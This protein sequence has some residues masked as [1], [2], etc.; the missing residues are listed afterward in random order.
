MNVKS[1]L[2]KIV[3]GKK[4]SSEDYIDHLRKK[5]AYVGTGTHFYSPAQI[6]ID[7]QYPWLIEIGNNVQL[8]AGVRI[9][10]HDYSWAV[11]KKIYGPVLGSAGKVKIEDNVFV[12]SNTVILGETHIGKNT[13]IGAGSVVKGKI[14]DNCVAVG[15]PCRPVESIHEYYKKRL[16][17]QF[18]EAKELAVSYYQH[19]GSIPPEELFFEFFFLF[20]G[21]DELNS[22]FTK[23]MQLVGNY[24]QSKKFLMNN[25]RMFK[26]YIEFI[27]TVLSNSK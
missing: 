8:T 23:Q 24:Q 5:G 6:S 21:S 4:A 12:G 7:E 17:R 3:L 25:I 13:I 20:K 2:L 18:K 9:L 15:N 11:L 22:I 27:S 26:D 1:K 19:T 10:T 14:P 16:D